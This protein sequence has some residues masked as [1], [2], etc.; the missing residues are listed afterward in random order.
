MYFMLTVNKETGKL[1][2]KKL[3]ISANEGCLFVIAKVRKKRETAI[4]FTV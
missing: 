1:V 4:G 3:R 2:D